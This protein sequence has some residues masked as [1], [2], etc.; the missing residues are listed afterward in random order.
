V[1]RWFESTQHHPNPVGVASDRVFYFGSSFGYRID[2][3]VN[4][5]GFDHN[6]HLLIITALNY[7]LTTWACSTKSVFITLILP[8]NKL[9]IFCDLNEA[10]EYLTGIDNLNRSIAYMFQP[11][12]H[13]NQVA[14]H[15]KW[16]GPCPYCFPGETPINILTHLQSQ[17]GRWQLILSPLYQKTP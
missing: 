6:F 11:S 8:T 5:P 16:S 1:S 4:R 3:S 10:T 14:S 15:G 2:N 13:K 9:R 7:S 17:W 12:N